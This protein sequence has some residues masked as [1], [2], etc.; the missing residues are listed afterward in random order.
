MFR[1][2]RHCWPILPLALVASGP[3][4][5]EELLFWPARID[6][7]VQGS[8]PR[9]TVVD[10]LDHD[11]RFDMVTV[12]GDQLTAF[13]AT[14]EHFVAPYHEL[15]GAVDEFVGGDV[16]ADGEL[17]IVTVN[18]EGAVEVWLGTGDGRFE[19]PDAVPYPGTAHTVHVGDDDGDGHLDLFVPP[20]DHGA[21]ADMAILRGT[22]DGTFALDRWVPI[23]PGAAYHMLVA[24]LSGD[25]RSD[26]VI[27]NY[28]GLVVR[29]RQPDGTYERGFSSSRHISGTAAVDVNGDGWTDLLYTPVTETAVR[30]ELGQPDGT[31]APGPSIDTPIAAEEC[32]PL[33]V[34]LD[35]DLDLAITGR[36]ADGK[37][38]WFWMARNRGDGTFE[39]DLDRH[40]TGEFPAGG[41]ATGDVT[42]DGVPD[43]WVRTSNPFV[44]LF[45]GEPDGG[46]T[47]VPVV[48]GPDY[49]LHIADVDGDGHL[50]VIGVYRSLAVRLGAGDGTF[51]APITSPRGDL[52]PRSVVVED[53]D[54]NGTKDLSLFLRD[55]DAGQARMELWRG[56][57]N[58]RFDPWP[59][60]S[61]AEWPAAVHHGDIDAD[62]FQDLITVE[63]FNDERT[64]RIRRGLG[65][66]TFD[67]PVVFFDGEVERG[68][69]IR[70]VHLADGDPYADL[71]HADAAGIAV[72]RGHAGGGFGAPIVTE[73][74]LELGVHAFL[75]HDVDLDGRLDVV[76]G[77]SRDRIALLSGDGRGKFT[78]RSS[79]EGRANQIVA[80]D[81][82]GDD[83][84]DL[85]VVRGE[86]NRVFLGR[87]D[88]QFEEVVI[89]Y[90]GAP[91][92]A[93]NTSLVDLD[94]DGR[95][96]LVMASGYFGG[97]G[98]LWGTGGRVTP[99]DPGDLPGVAVGLRPLA[100][101]VRPNPMTGAARI[102]FALDEASPVTV[103]IH[104]LLGRQVRTLVEGRWFASGRHTVTWDEATGDGSVPSGTYFVRVEGRA[105][106][107][108][109]RLVR[110][111]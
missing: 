29:V 53:L 36:E 73:Y 19:G 37:E 110:V 33:D 14:S 12:N 42:G 68:D 100:V 86:T 8:R 21:Y 3:S 99:I 101:A 41:M 13:L 48:A 40:L 66:G 26:L 102:E 54:G 78:L 46:M 9:T 4:G 50:D 91:L 51:S 77:N 89:G 18:A 88:L 43:V 17:D 111:R 24:D 64:I 82:D 75:V 32:I 70:L 5:A 25:A 35:G 44:S 71:I 72:Y 57:G 63:S 106:A 61:I 11:G 30:I 74:T 16:N 80:G 109:K 79:L 27:R 62:G 39:L 34:D 58:G 96:D 65:D 103:R 76:L 15:E 49:P 47:R 108:V 22:G 105:G 2:R 7:P 20:A 85:V 45:L 31:L 1:P 92:G 6:L 69:V 83:V 94:E 104:D 90:G 87:G 38:D 60:V 56:Q 10:D 59:D 98:I 84:T 28:Y 23:D 95:L 97:L 81:L 55:G 107:S 52:Y 93:E 67:A